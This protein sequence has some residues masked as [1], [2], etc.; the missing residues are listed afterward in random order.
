MD[1]NLLVPVLIIASVLI[2]GLYNLQY[3]ERMIQTLLPSENASDN[4]R[5]TDSHSSGARNRR[6]SEDKRSSEARLEEKEISLEVALSKCIHE[7]SD[8]GEEVCLFEFGVTGL[9]DINREN[10][11]CVGDRI[12]QHIVETVRTGTRDNDYIIRRGERVFLVAITTTAHTGRMLFL[13]LQ[14]ALE[15]HSEQ[16]SNGKVIELQVSTGMATC[17]PSSDEV[18]APLIKKLIRAANRDFQKLPPDDV[19][20]PITLTTKNLDPLGSQQYKAEKTY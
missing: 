11:N 17:Q 1:Y 18:P 20:G 16:A 4:K 2:F 5:T 7:A 14:L 8:C 13:R 12:I 19:A 9:H 6:T 15:G 10:G 3:L